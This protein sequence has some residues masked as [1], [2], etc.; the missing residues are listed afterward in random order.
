MKKI[1]KRPEA[2]VI[3]I[4]TMQMMASSAVEDGFS[5]SGAKE[6]E[7]TSGNLSRRYSGA[8]E[9]EE[10]EEEEEEF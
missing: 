6:T 2:D 5:K 7:G 9:E 8:W 3:L 1:Y 10:L 4:T